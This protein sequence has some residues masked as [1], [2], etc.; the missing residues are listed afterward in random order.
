MIGLRYLT[1]TKECD[2]VKN[3]KLLPLIVILLILVLELLPFGAV[4]IDAPPDGG[5]RAC[6]CFSL[7]PFRQ[8]NV[9]PLVTA[10]LTCIMFGI[11][12]AYFVKPMPNLVLIWKAMLLT[13]I[14]TSI[15][16]IRYL[17]Y[18]VGSVVIS[19]LLILEYILI[20]SYS[21]K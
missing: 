4:V 11:A 18:S 17:S 3:R 2:F 7:A 20:R 9:F 8:G 16:P 5:M 6:S 13:S 1:L 21:E 15:A 19:A 14:L 12:L 10:I